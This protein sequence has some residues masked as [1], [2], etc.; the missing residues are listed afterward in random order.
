MWHVWEIGEVHKGFWCGDLRIRG[1]LEDLGVEGKIILKWVFKK[2]DGE[3][4]TGLSWLGIRTVT[5][6]DCKYGSEP[7][8]YMKYRESI[9]QL[10]N[11]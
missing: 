3:T 1:H 10:R 4:W 2:W 9:E 8:G 6:G 11:C 5:A 7:S